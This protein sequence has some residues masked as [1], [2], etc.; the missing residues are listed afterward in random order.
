MNIHLR[1]VLRLENIQSFSEEL[2]TKEYALYI[3]KMQEHLK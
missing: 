2:Y 3:Y 1:H